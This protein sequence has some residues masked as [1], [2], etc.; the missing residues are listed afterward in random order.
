VDV[1]P[2]NKR[3]QYKPYYHYEQPAEKMQARSGDFR[4]ILLSGGT[5]EPQRAPAH[6]VGDQNRSM[7]GLRSLRSLVPPYGFGLEVQ[8]TRK[9]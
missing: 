7:V 9:M 6:R 8:P 2:D 5:S 1:R 3:K 4:A